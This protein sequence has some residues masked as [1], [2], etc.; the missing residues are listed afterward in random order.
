[1]DF[2]ALSANPSGRSFRTPPGTIYEWVILLPLAISANSTKS[3]LSA[4]AHINIVEWPINMPRIA[5]QYSVYWI[6][7]I[8]ANITL[9]YMALSGTCNPISS[10]TA[11]QYEYSMLLESCITGRSICGTF[12]TNVL[13]SDI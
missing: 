1:M 6:L 11:R 10:S 4:V 9:R 12:W 13:N 7:S 3:S 2:N 8:S 5:S